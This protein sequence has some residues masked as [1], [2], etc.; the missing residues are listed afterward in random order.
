MEYL[1]TW[2]FHAVTHTSLSLEGSADLTSA[3]PEAQAG[4]TV[5]RALSPQAA[6]GR[7]RASHVGWNSVSASVPRPHRD[8]INSAQDPVGRL[9][10]K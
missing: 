7:G 3:G 6:R 2:T 1:L 4:A 9:P 5:R 10:A 8:A